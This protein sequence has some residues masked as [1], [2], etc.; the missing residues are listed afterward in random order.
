MLLLLLCFFSVF[1]CDLE[2]VPDYIFREI[3]ASDH[4]VEKTDLPDQLVT[5]VSGV[6]LFAQE[7]PRVRLI[8]SYCQ[9]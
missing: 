6:E 9:T 3:K 7:F 1:Y 4:V 2:S 8:S 5:Q